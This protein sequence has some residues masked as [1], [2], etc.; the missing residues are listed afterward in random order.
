MGR[1]S[2][3]EA[4]KPDAGVLT[5]VRK[6]AASASKA[7]SSS[8]IVSARAKA[9]QRSDGKALGREVSLGA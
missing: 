4:C 5:E 6:S 8:V 3:A 7:K 9:K 1:T 2:E